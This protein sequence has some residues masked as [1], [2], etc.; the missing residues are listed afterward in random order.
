MS[1]QSKLKLNF[2]NAE[3]E[4][5]ESVVNTSS[6]QTSNN[7]LARSKKYFKLSRTPGKIPVKLLVV[8]DKNRDILLEVEQ[9]LLSETDK[10]LKGYFDRSLRMM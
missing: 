7:L 10:S 3:H 6:Q 8:I 4:M 9:V 1:N 5:K 2:F